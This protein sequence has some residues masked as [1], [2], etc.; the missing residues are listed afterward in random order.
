[1]FTQPYYR[2]APRRLPLVLFIFMLMGCGLGDPGGESRYVTR[3]GLGPDKWVSAWVLTR[4]HEPRSSLHL[5]GDSEAPGSG[6]VLFDDPESVLRRSS[7]RSAFQ[8]I[9][10]AHGIEDPAVAAL[11][12]IIHAIEVDFWSSQLTPNAMAIERAFRTLQRGSGGELPT[13]ECYLVFF[14]RVYLALRQSLAF[15]R[16]LSASE[17]AVSCDQSTVAQALDLEKPL[18]PEVSIPVLLAELRRGKS[19]AFVDVRESTEFAEAHIP[20][21]LNIPIHGL[22]EADVERLRGMDYV[23]SYCVKDFRGFEM[24]KKLRGRGVDSSVILK[25]Y[26]IAGWIGNGLPV[27]GTG[28]LNEEQA[29]IELARCLEEQDCGVPL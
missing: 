5:L 7:N 19:V 25:P 1:M 4:Y 23:V 8:T 22:D 24:A 29:G 15:G 2:A 20:G 6:D 11:V 9:V 14:D 12:E 28:A 16:P 17:L 27:A 10:E 13:P 21:A 3:S 26:G 18:V